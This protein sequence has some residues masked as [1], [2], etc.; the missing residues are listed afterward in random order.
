MINFLFKMLVH[1]FFQ[2]EVSV[3]NGCSYFCSNLIVDISVQHWLLM[4]VFLLNFDNFV[5]ID[6]WYFCPNWYFS[7]NWL[8]RILFKFIVH[9]FNQIDSSFSCWKCLFMFLFK[10]IVH[11]LFKNDCWFFCSNWLLI[12]PFKLVVYFF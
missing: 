1:V 2:F 8:F 4:F 3:Q 9:I 11:F 10:L 6:C 7:S 5:Q 12:Y